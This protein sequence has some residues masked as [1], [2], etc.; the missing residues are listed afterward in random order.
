MAIQQTQT[1]GGQLDSKTELFEGAVASGAV[2][3]GE[4]AGTASAGTGAPVNVHGGAG[5]SF[6]DTGLATPVD[7]AGLPVNT[8]VDPSIKAKMVEGAMDEQASSE[9]HMRDRAAA[10]A[11]AAQQLAS[12]GTATSASTKTSVSGGA[13]TPAPTTTGA[14]VQPTQAKA[15]AWQQYADQASQMKFD[16]NSANDPAYLQEA[17]NLENQVAGMMVGRG[18]LYSSL[19]Q[20]ALQSRL[21]TL[22]IEMRQQR[23]DEFLQERNWMMDMAGFYADR[24][25]T[26]FTQNL[27]MLNYQLD[28]EQQKF[29]QQM[30]RAELSLAQAKF[31]YSKEQAALAEKESSI[32]TQYN[33]L[34][35]QYK[36]YNEMLTEYT[37]RW[38]ESKY[39]DAEVQAFFGLSDP[40]MS[41]WSKSAQSAI[42]SKTA[43]VD[44][45]RTQA[46]ALAVQANDLDRAITA[47]QGFVTGSAASIAKQTQETN[48][49]DM[50][51]QIL[52]AI[53]TKEEAY[54]ILNNLRD[55]KANIISYIGETNYN[56]LMTVVAN[57][58]YS[59]AFT[60]MKNG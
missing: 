27:Q 54:D 2:G 35:S 1:D 38:Y 15:G 16:W 37:D 42:N 17:S 40:T 55:D 11:A 41:Y 47:S 23:Y 21:T 10:D 13:P 20:S 8:S 3:T 30:Q 39:P 34:S 7:A 51:T 53:N 45:L 24:E 14:A 52:R 49:N 43:S 19:Y 58:A 25:D 60:G 48:Y 59:P 5:R 28:L 56:S 31:A 18:M 4:I 9:Q 50:K 12:S 33:D 32:K 57:A 22:Q 26:A 46:E 36:S 29:S 44:A 6:A